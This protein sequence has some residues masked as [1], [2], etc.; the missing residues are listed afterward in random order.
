MNYIDTS[1]IKGEQQIRFAHN[2]NFCHHQ[3]GGDCR[4]K[5]NFDD[6]L[7]QR[8]KQS[9]AKSLETHR[10]IFYEDLDLRA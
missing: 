7:R 4:F 3:K 9:V 2:D 6:D 8:I 1:Y 5:M 10:Q